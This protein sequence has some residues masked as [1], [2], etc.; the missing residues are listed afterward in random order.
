AWAAS[1][2]LASRSRARRTSGQSAA[3]CRGER[4]P[5]Q[6]LITNFWVSNR[7]VEAIHWSRRAAASPGQHTADQLRIVLRPQVIFGI[8]E[9]LAVLIGHNDRV[10]DNNIE[11]LGNVARIR[12]ARGAGLYD[13]PLL[14]I[15]LGQGD[16]G[17][18]QGLSL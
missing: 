3:P 16:T 10:I 2:L 8:I 14:T 12:A 11:A 1:L 7:T 4:P 13:D 5:P 18:L 15:L 9:R 17:A 6:I